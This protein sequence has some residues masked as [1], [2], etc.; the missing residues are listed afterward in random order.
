MN[1]VFIS[2][3]PHPP[4]KK[5][6]DYIHVTQTGSK[7]KAKNQNSRT[8]L[9]NL[10]SVMNVEI[11]EGGYTIRFTHHENHKPPQWFRN[12]ESLAVGL[13]IYT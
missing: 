13:S 8:S 5:P 4:S 7:T 10:R 1:D 9:F 2:T 12:S 3:H 11:K 6:N